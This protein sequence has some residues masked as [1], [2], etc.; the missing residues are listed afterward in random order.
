MPEP[1]PEHPTDTHP[2]SLPPSP[3]PVSSNSEIQ[4]DESDRS[5]DVQFPCHLRPATL[6]DMQGVAEIHNLEVRSSHRTIDSNEV[7]EADFVQLYHKLRAQNAPFVV[8]VKGWHGGGGRSSKS[9]AAAAAVIGFAFVDVLTP[10]IAGSSTT[11]AATCGR[12]TLIVHPRYRKKRVGTALMDVILSCCSTDH[13]PYG[14]YQFVNPDSS[15][16]RRFADPASSN[17][18]KWRSLY[19]EIPIISSPPKSQNRHFGHMRRLT[20]AEREK[21]LRQH[22][23]W[24]MAEWLDQRFAMILVE[25]RSLVYKHTSN[26]DQRKSEWLDCLVMSHL[27][28]MDDF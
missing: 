15:N 23:E 1:E 3:S 24:W 8:T 22:D 20:P 19:L 27:C 7:P 28:R 25:H 9:A 11:C 26:S 10:G 18:R 2:D 16:D 13:H 14:G 17:P 12:V 21:E 5:T 6:A 4:Q